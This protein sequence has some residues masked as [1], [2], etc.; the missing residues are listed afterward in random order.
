M[1]SKSQSTRRVTFSSG[2]WQ[3]Q[4]DEPGRPPPASQPTLLLH[5]YFS[6]SLDKAL[7]MEESNYTSRCFELFLASM[8][9]GLFHC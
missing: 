7:E 1:V 8:C 2:A 9:F 5:G 6:F 3:Q 4:R